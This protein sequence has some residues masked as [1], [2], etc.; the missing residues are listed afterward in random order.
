VAVEKSIIPGLPYHHN[1]AS[2]PAAKHLLVAPAVAINNSRP[3]SVAL[4]LAD[5]LGCRCR[6]PRL[7]LDRSV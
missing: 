2:P 3:S 4:V 7:G 5:L 6:W 1:G